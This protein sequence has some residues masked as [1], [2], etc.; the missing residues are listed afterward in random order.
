MM[1]H[2]ILDRQLTLCHAPGSS[3]KRVLQNI[4]E[5]LQDKLGNVDAE[6][7]FEQ[8]IAREKLGS[9]GIERTVS[10][11]VTLKEPVDFDAHDHQP[12]DI[13]FLLIV[14]ESAT[15]D[16]LQIVAELAVLLDDAEFRNRLRQSKNSDELF[17]VATQL[18]QAA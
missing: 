17:L 18:A 4:S 15:D 14:P 16:H 7:I 11:L 9:T 13:L 1:I 2:R 10:C 5:F 8:V 6:Q 3:K 12:V